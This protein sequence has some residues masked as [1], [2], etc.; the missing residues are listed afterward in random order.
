MDVLI[1]A[2]KDFE[3]DLD[4]LNQ[5]SRSTVIE[6][7]NHCASLFP[8][9]KVDGYRNLHQLPLSIDL[10]GYD[11]SLYTLE[12][13]QKLRV[14]LAVDEDPIFGQI[15]FTLF[16]AIEHDKLEMAYKAV[17]DT[18]YPEFRHHDRVPVPHR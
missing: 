5:A 1:E 2:T 13:S 11:S 15:I 3:Q 9:Q 4:N 8:A 10:N 17:A 6:K 7:I 16:R 18:I 14:I 12:I